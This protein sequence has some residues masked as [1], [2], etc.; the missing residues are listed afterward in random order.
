[1][2]DPRREEACAARNRINRVPVAL[3]TAQR[4]ADLGPA[5]IAAEEYSV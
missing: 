3:T 4:A 1:M 2:R 5:Q